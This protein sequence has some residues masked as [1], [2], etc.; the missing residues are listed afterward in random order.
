MNFPLANER[1]RS[2]DRYHR[3]IIIK[4]ARA[5]ECWGELV[6]PE[7]ACSTQ[8]EVE[9]V[10]RN[11]GAAVERD[12][13]P[14]SCPSRSPGPR[15]KQCFGAKRHCLGVVGRLRCG[16]AQSRWVREREPHCVSLLISLSP[17]ISARPLAARG[18]SSAA[19]AVAAF[20][21]FLWLQ[22]LRSR[23][24]PCAMLVSCTTHDALAIDGGG[25]AV[26]FA[27]DNR[28]GRERGQRCDRESASETDRQRR[29]CLLFPNKLDRFRP[30]PLSLYIT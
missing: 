13:S 16:Q 2:A 1:M 30:L 23:F 29:Q 9:F 3:I 17:C 7:V 15:D 4:G 6:R 14:W 11:R 25:A 21:I 18:S 27:L 8:C 5:S 20:F 19:A 26:V 22:A 24:L 10:G 12:G 28:Q